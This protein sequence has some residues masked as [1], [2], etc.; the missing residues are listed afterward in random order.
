MTAQILTLIDKQ[1]N[2]EAVRD[3]IGLILAEESANQQLLATGEGKDPNL[4]KLRVYVERSNPWETWLNGNTDRSPIINVW[5]DNATTLERGSDVIKTQ[6]K[7]V[8]YNIDCYGLGVSGGDVAGQL[9]GDKEAAL[10]SH[11]G[12]RLCRNILMA[13]HYTYLGLR[14]IVGRRMT[15][16]ITAFQPE[17]NGRAVQ[18]VLATRIQ[19]GVL[20]IEA[21]PQATGEPIEY[22][23][24]ELKRAED[25]QILAGV[26]IDYTT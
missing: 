19:L 11:R 16:S 22:L 18:N 7:E 14:G 5:F 4:W 26:D 3:Q 24:I 1:D 6:Q 10:N 23:S 9:L 13:A 15:R 21:S 20:L 12:T 8:V 17:I 25:G 2:F